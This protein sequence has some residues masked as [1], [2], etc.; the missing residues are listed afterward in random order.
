VPT[1]ITGRD[2]HTRYVTP[3]RRVLCPFRMEDGGTIFVEL[4]VNE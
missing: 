2:F 1:V 4:I 3:V